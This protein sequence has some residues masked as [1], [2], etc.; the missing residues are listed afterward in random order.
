MRIGELG[1]F[2]GGRG[3]QIDPG[4][5]TTPEYA[6]AIYDGVAWVKNARGGNFTSGDL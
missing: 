4:A 1:R 6:P 2:G 3:A 5:D